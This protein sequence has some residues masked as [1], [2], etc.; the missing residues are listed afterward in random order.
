MALLIITVW[1]GDRE[2]EVCIATYRPVIGQSQHAKSVSH[3]IK[4]NIIEYS[5]EEELYS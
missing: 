1:K 5:K 3:I 4:Y 2:L